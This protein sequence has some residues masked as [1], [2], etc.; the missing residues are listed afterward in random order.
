MNINKK[1][2]KFKNHYN[3][4]SGLKVILLFSLGYSL[5]FI[6]LNHSRDN[7]C[8]KFHT[9]GKAFVKRKVTGANALVVTLSRR[10]AYIHSFVKVVKKYYVDYNIVYYNLNI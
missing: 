6:E 3:E 5:W 9:N 4:I 1:I 7:R 8:K 2:N 10:N